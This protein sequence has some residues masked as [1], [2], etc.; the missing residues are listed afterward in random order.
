MVL[1]K[2]EQSISQKIEQCKNEAGELVIHQKIL[3]EEIVNT[4]VKDLITRR[5]GPRT[6]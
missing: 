4:N 3:D 5:T 1:L 2:D 6:K